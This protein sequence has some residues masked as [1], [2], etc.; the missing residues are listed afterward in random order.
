MLPAE[1]RVWFGCVLR[2]PSSAY[3][4]NQL[5]LGGDLQEEK[6]ER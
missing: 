3:S 2:C 4:A 6:R 5:R 1:L